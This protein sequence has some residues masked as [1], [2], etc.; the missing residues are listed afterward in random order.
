LKS[1]TEAFFFSEPGYKYLFFLMKALPFEY[2]SVL[3][4]LQQHTDTSK[5]RFVG[6]QHCLY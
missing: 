1:E 2:F 5:M 3:L 6:K 4:Y